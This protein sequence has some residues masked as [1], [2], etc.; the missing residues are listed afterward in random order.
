MVL[1]APTPPTSSATAPRPRS[2][3]R[4]VFSVACLAVSASE[5]RE[6]STSPGFS[7]LAVAPL[8]RRYGVDPDQL[9]VVQD[10]LDLP[11]G[12]LKV[13][14]GGG[15]AGHNGLRSIKAHLH[16][17]AFLRVRIGVGKPVSKE[18]GAD[19]VLKKFSKRERAEI[20]VVIEEAADAVELIVADGV[21]A[22][23]NRVNTR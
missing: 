2:R 15:L 13:K 23:M 3:P 16:S 8:V 18:H 22:A 17:D 10:E 21:D 12:V 11:V 9:V 5:G 19:H 6:T 20:D 7:G 1:A 14:D 4:S